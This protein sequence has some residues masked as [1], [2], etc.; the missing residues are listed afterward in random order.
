MSSH[1]APATDPLGRDE[2]LRCAARLHRPE[3]AELALQR[4]WGVAATLAA[5]QADESLQLAGGL[6]ATVHGGPEEATEAFIASIDER[7]VAELTLAAVQFLTKSPIPLNGLH[8]QDGLDKATLAALTERG[9]PLVLQRINAFCAAYRNPDIAFLYAAF[10]WQRFQQAQRSDDRARRAFCDEARLL[11]APFLEMLGMR[12]LRSM[13]DRWLLHQAGSTR[14]GQA[15]QAGRDLAWLTSPLQNA[16]PTAEFVAARYT[17]TH[18]SITDGV[19]DSTFNTQPTLLI[20]VLVD[21]VAACYTALYEINRHY[22]PVDGGLIDN[23]AVGR[24]NDYRCLSTT[25]IAPV[26]S[27]AAEAHSGTNGSHSGR[28]RVRVQFRIATR[29]FDAINRWGLAAYR[30]HGQHA[31]PRAS[32]WWNDAA[33]GQAKIA[34]DL[35]GRLPLTLYV[36][37]PHGQLFQFHRGCTV[38]DYAYFVHSDL[39]DQCLHFKVNGQRVEPSTVLR[40]L[41]LVELEH[42]AHAPGPTQVWLNAARTSRARSK[43]KRFL[44]RRGQD[45]FQGERIVREQLSRLAEHYRFPIPNYRVQQEI[46]RLLPYLQIAS[47]DDFYREVAGGRVDARSVLNRVYAK[48]LITQ[49]A[50]PEGLRPQPKLTLAQCCRPRPNNAIVGRAKRRGGA[51]FTLKVHRT[52]CPHI[53]DLN[54][55]PED[56]IAL[57]WKTRPRLKL[58][59]QLEMSALNEDGLLGDA[60]AQIYAVAP[61]ATLHRSEAVA[62]RGVAHINFVIEAANQTIIDQIATSLKTLPERTVTRVRVLDVS[63]T[64]RDDLASVSSSAINNPYSRMPVNER[65]MFFGRRRELERISNDLHGNIGAIWLRGQKRVGKTSLLLHLKHVYLEPHAFVPVYIDFQLINGMDSAAS[66]FYQVATAVYSDLQTSHYRADSHID[67]L[68]PPIRELFD[69]EPGRQLMDYLTNIQSRLSQGRLVVLMDEFSRAIDAWHKARLHDDFLHQWRGV[70]S[71][72]TGVNFI[73]V[74]QQKTYNDLG[75]DA[76]DGEKQDRRDPKPVWELLE[77]GEQLVLRPLD[78][79]NV[80]RLIEWPIRDAVEYPPELVEHVATLTGGSPFLI[81]AFC[82]KLVTEMNRSHSTH[83]TR[84]DVERAQM[85]FMQPN[86]SVFAHLLD[87]IRGIAQLATQAL[88]D[89]SNDAPAEG[90]SWTQLREAC[91][92]IKPAQLRNALDKLTEQDVLVE[93]KNGQWRFASLLFQQWLYANPIA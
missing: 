55:R 90:A 65:E 37:S 66:V 14:F 53:S 23:L 34:Q 85:G 20:D 78:E 63:R 72:A 45:V 88:A 8:W 93:V 27:D 58:L 82:A 18:N 22:Q 6:A 38:V 33:A 28:K 26:N 39:A 49:I 16:L 64:E 92:E 71:H 5:W 32:S 25:V 4:G 91:P 46:R 54:E 21:E 41:D 60:L 62:R 52:D 80:R 86:E 24:I 47:L 74:I 50:P 89:L 17:Q 76:R 59:A 61:G 15:E 10:L 1:Q 40:H 57:T 13:V 43:I 19:V 35:P 73:T 83:I 12:E 9:E 36:F 87:L 67:E 56:A 48:E 77:L 2:R 81:Q 3:Q 69:H 44:K 29:E 11:L 42:D 7:R 30:L 70:I 79:D 31:T 84:T 51:I 68:G 75:N